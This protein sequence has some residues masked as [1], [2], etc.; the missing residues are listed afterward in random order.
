M[1]LYSLVSASARARMRPRSASS[2]ATCAR[3]EYHEY[4]TKDENRNTT[5]SMM[6]K[7]MR[8]PMLQLFQK[9]IFIAA[10]PAGGART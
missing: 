2:S 3:C 5:G 10:G 4:Q 6:M 7:I 9:R 1:T 8:V